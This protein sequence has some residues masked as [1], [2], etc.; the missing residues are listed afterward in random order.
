MTIAFADRP[1][2]TRSIALILVAAPLVGAAFGADEPQG[3]AAKKAAKAAVAAKADGGEAG[4]RAKARQIAQALGEL[5]AALGENDAK[6][7]GK[8][9]SAALPER[10]KKTIS[11]PSLDPAGLDSL[12]EQALTKAKT[13][14]P[15]VTTD[16]EF[17]RR[18]YLDVTGRLPT[19]PEMRA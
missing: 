18:V 13:P 5:Q 9:K 12:V 7:K 2:W 15:P 4:D 16:E 6:G 1:R 10:P 17:V 14:V 3:K 19:I 11:P 8:A